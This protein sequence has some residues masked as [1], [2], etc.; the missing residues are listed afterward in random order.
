MGRRHSNR[1]T[2]LLSPL[3]IAGSYK[4]KLIFIGEQLITKHSEIKIRPILKCK[5]INTS[6]SKGLLYINSV[7]KIC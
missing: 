7:E 4:I 6:N 2:S 1:S 5:P 3:Q